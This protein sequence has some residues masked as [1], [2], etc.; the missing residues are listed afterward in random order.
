MQEEFF[1]STRFERIG[2]G[3][4]FGNALFE[5]KLKM[6]QLYGIITLLPDNKYLK[7]YK[8]FKG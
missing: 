4:K 2:I 1:D 3:H 5:A 8:A 6:L 7:I